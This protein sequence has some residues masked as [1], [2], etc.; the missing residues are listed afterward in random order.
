MTQCGAKTR[1]GAPCTVR[2]MPNGR[3]YHH[4]GASLAGMASPTFKTGRYSK[5]LPTRLLDRYHEG[6]ADRD[7]LALTDEIAVVNAHL[8]E[9]IGELDIGG[10]AAKWEAI[11]MGLDFC[12]E[13]I[14]AKD[15]QRLQ[16][17]L[18]AMRTIVAEGE[19]DGA[20]WEEIGNW[21]ERARKL[22]ETEQRRLVAMQQVI[23][24]EQAMVLVAALTMAVKTHVHDPVALRAINDEFV[25]T[26]ATA[27]TD[28]TRRQRSGDGAL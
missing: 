21:M 7:L 28:N 26:L 14:V 3:C 19:E 4:G 25:R 9:L 1:K 20:K 23:T 17:H 6:L 2:A 8:G 13:A 24:S 15:L 5:V 10:S 27:G 18:A 22:R 11:G 16:G 12:D